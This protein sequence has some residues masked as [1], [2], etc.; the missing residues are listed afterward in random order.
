VP[1]DPGMTTLSDFYYTQFFSEHIG[2]AFGK[3][4]F[5]G[6]DQNV[7]AH[8]E[9]TQFMNLALL[10][11]PVLLS[12]APYSALT[13]GV[14]FKPT[15]WLSGSV[16]VLDSYGRP[17]TTGF[18]TAFHT[19]NGMTLLSEWDFT[20]RPFGLPGHQRVGFAY[21]RKTFKELDQDLRLG[22]PGIRS[23]RRLVGNL[24][25]PETRPDDWCLYYNFDQYVYTEKADPTQG[26]GLFGR[27]GW[28]SGEANP[29][30]EFYSIG[31]GGKGII[32]TRDNDTFG[33]GYYYVNLSDDLP[34][35][36]G[37]NSEQ[38]V[39][40][41]YN[42][43]IAPWLHVSPDLQVIVDPGGSSDNDVAIVYG[44]RM[45]MSL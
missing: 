19:P 28:S 27:F 38:G 7:F 6:G 41:Y 33:V 11:N 13:A 17:D 21:A 8:D 1:D 30:S 10:A 9:N 20:I 44:L 23:L 4:D 36:F 18:D 43:E 39:E 45:H 40:L 2:I 34:S 31:V 14:F 3:I 37:L 29:I 24:A 16:I 22:L 25:N 32:P 15:E 5:R 12:Y 35:F 42:I 26:V